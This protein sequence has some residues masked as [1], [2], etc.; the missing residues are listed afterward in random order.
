MR[1]VE[2]LPGLFSSALGFGC[3]PILGSVDAN[4]SRR[5]LS[6]ALDAGITHFDLARSYGYGQ[7]ERFVGRHLKG[8]RDSVTITTKFGIAASPLAT[9]LIPIK[10]FVRRLRASRTN[11]ACSAPNAAETDEKQS[12]RRVP[13]ILLRRLPIT[14]KTMRKSLEKS[15]RALGSD[16]VDIFLVHETHAPVVRSEEILAEAAKLVTEGKIRGFGISY[17]LS[18]EPLHASYL[19]KFHVHQ[20]DVPFGGVGLSEGGAEPSR[21]PRV[22]FSPF[23]HLK[24]RSNAPE[25][26][27]EIA[28]RFPESVVLCSMFKPE[29][30]RSNAQSFC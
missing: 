5:A 29:H 18:Q 11:R 24:A 12:G 23:Q 2:L 30:I 16:Y 27:K 25:R 19:S 1:Q 14:V 20:T 28:K 15:L 17:M 21:H 9:A 7:A 4:T 26:L 13:D 3:A 8:L 10:P 22:L 6:Q